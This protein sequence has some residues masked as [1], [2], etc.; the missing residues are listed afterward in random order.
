MSRYRITRTGG[1]YVVTAE[2]TP[3][4]PMKVTAITFATRA[5]ALAYVAN[6]EGA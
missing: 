3:F 4:D 2:T 6:P 5:E 1:R